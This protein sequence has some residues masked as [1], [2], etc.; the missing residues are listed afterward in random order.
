MGRPLEEDPGFSHYLSAIQ[1]YAP[2]DRDQELKLA[3]RW[4]RRGDREAADALVR[5]NLRFVVKLANQYRG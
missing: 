5:A 3:R 1:Q 4:V 2:L